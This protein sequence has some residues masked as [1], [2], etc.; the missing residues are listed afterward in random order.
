MHPS[1]SP[2]GTTIPAPRKASSNE[3]IGRTFRCS[4]TN[5]DPLP[6]LA[7]EP[8]CDL[9]DRS[10]GVAVDTRGAE[11]ALRADDPLDRLRRR[12]RGT[13][14]MNDVEG[15]VSVKHQIARRRQPCNLLR[16]Q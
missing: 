9:A 16:R 10:P 14:T 3:P 11:R 13:R 8:R 6:G 4:A 1:E 2:T 12:E 15:I 7:A 5:S